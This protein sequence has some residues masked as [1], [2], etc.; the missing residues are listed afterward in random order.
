MSTLVQPTGAAIEISR[1]SKVYETHDDEDVVAL[2]KIDLRFE[3]GSFVAVVGPSGCGKSTLLSLLAGL[4]SASTGRIAIDGQEIS[5]PH[6]KIGVVFQSDLLLY[7][8]T[9]LDNILLPIEIKKLDLSRF[10]GRAEEL[11]AQVGLEG[12]GSKYPSELSGGMR[13][14]VAIC[15]ALIQEPGLLLMDEPFGALDALTREQ[16]IMDLQSMWLRVRNTVLF[17]THG[18]D[19]AVFLADRVLVMSPRPGRIDLDLKID[20]PRPRQ[21]SKVHEDKAYHGHVRQIRDIFEAKGILVA[22]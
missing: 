8:R 12:F 21:W 20:M 6:P 19:E 16:M 11:L 5:R 14:R 15:R 22:H 18:I 10:R 13:Q 17:I 2:E 1:L 7:W 9:V 4:T 3:P